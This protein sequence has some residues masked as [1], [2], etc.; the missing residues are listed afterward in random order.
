MRV[1]R[2]YVDRQAV[3]KEAQYHDNEITRLKCRHN[4]TQKTATELTNGAAVLYLGMTSLPTTTEVMN[5]FVSSTHFS[6]QRV[7]DPRAE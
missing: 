5:D 2:S 6:L 7:C 4:Q 1:N 3:P